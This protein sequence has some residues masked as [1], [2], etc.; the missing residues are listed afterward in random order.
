MPGAS[1]LDSPTQQM[2]L[3]DPSLTEPPLPSRGAR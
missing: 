2:P 3:N 1:V